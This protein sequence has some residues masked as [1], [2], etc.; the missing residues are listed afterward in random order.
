MLVSVGRWSQSR[1]RMRASCSSGS[2]EEGLQLDLVG[3]FSAQCSTNGLDNSDQHDYG[4]NYV[5]QFN[6]TS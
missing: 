3:R 6:S 5:A 2:L 4:S 1:S